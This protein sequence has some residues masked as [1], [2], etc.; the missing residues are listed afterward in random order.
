M[1]FYGWVGKLLK[2]DLSNG[3]ITREPLDEKLAMGFIGGRG[4]GSK[5]LWDETG[6]ETDPFGP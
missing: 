3:T 5:L 2:M 4:I 6:P 1:Q